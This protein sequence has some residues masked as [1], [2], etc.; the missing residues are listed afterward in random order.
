MAATEEHGLHRAGRPAAARTRGSSPAKAP[1]STT[2]TAPGLLHARHRPQPVRPRADQEHRR[3]AGPLGRPASSPRAHRRGPQG[4]VAERAAVHLAGV[5]RHQDAAAPARSPSTRRAT[6]ATASR[7]SSPRAARRR[8]TRPSSSRS[9]TSA[10]PAVTDVEKALDD[11][12]PLVHDDVAREP[13]LHVVARRAASPTSVFAEAARRRQGALPPAAADPDPRWSRAASSCE[14]S[15]RDRRRHGRHVDAGAAHHAHG[16]RAR[17]RDPRGQDPRH[18]AGRRRRLRLQDRRVRRGHARHRLRPKARPARSSGSRSAP[19][20]ASPRSTAATSSRRSSSPPT[21]TGRS[22]ASGCDLTAAMGAYLQAVTPGIPLL[23]AW[24]Y[25]G[26]LRL[27]SHTTST[28]RACSRTRPRP[29]PTAA[30]GA[31][32]RPTRSSGRWTR[33]RAA[34]G[35][36]P[37]EIRRMNFIR[38]FPATIASGLEIDSGDFEA[39][40]DRGSSSSTTTAFGASRTPGGQ[41]GDRSSSAS[42]SPP[43]SRCAGSRPPASSARSSTAAAAGRR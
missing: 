27:Q 3:L 37:V 10:L 2:T 23:G 20:P 18:R 29:T 5:G 21:R 1:T 8:R 32:R 43:T 39:S 42:A 35:K 34:V 6:S 41:R 13:L 28:A 33:W 19:K 16:L 24:L 25:A 17:H 31:P 11:G 22:R 26:V 9:T 7:S 4:C 15:P 38:E 40:L 12:A 30:P 14:I 36:D